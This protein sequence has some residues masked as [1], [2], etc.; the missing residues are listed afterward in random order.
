M[1]VRGFICGSCNNNAGRSW[2][3]ALAS[4]LH[5]LSLLF[6]IRRRRGPIPGLEVATTAGERVVMK[7]DGSFS[8][9][10]P[11]YSMERTEAGIKIGIRA[12]SLREARKMLSGVKR[13]YPQID[14]DR[15]LAGA[16]ISTTPL[17]GAVHHQLAFGGEIAGRSIVKS[18]LALAHLAGVPID[19]CHDALSYLRD[20]ARS[21][22]FGYYYASDLLRARPVDMPL[23]CVS[24]EAN[25]ETGLILG[26]AEYFGV[27][28]V[29]V[30]L[31]RT[32]RGDRAEKTYALDPRTGQ[33]L[34][35]SVRL[36]FGA[37]EIAA[38][39]D[40][41]MAPGGA[42]EE[43]FAAV[44][45]GAL[46]RRFEMQR[47]RAAK[48]AA[49]YAFANCG[50]RLGEILTEEHFKKFVGLFTERMVQFLL[51]SAGSWPAVPASDDLPP[52]PGSDGKSDVAGLPAM[53]ARLR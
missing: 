44:M 41:R 22:C 5:P 16:Q 51:R 24:V 36:E 48:Q 40:D 25:P 33:A 32:Y 1:Q 43:A 39:F 21:P 29:V 45:P 50:A 52:A 34:D 35:L 49:E 26:Y 20:P 4:Q 28:R 15:I 42:I 6:S 9:I 46:R 53:R 12:R 10:H 37:S 19:L 23:H 47:E 2:D 14:S 27:R 3:A 30:C 8:P 11:T 18:T 7:P 17:Q 31:G 13:K 38:I